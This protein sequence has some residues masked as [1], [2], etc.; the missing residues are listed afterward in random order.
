MSQYIGVYVKT[1]NLCNRTK[2]QHCRPSGELHLTETPE[3]QWQVISVNF[4]ME[5]PESH[6]YDAIMNMVDSVSK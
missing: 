1:C 3:E 5:L 6:G 4:I 2:L